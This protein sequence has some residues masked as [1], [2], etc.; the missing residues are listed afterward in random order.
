MTRRRVLISS[1]FPFFMMNIL[2]VEK[3]FFGNALS[4]KKAVGEWTDREASFRE[5]KGKVI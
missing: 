1:S 3:R 5:L 2:N 4:R